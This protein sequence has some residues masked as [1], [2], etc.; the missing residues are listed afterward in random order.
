MHP[1]SIQVII[2]GRAYEVH[3]V[4]GRATD[5]IVFSNGKPFRNIGLVGPK[6]TA[7]IIA[8]NN[9]LNKTQS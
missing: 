3:Y 6:A 4:A 1:E 7:A 9:L 8:A 2:N 5:V